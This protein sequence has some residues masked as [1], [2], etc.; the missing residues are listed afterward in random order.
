MRKKLD[1]SPEEI[2][3]LAVMELRD[4]FKSEAPEILL[5]IDPG[6]VLPGVTIK[7]PKRGDKKHLLD[8]SER[9]ARYYKIM[10]EHY[11][12]QYRACCIRDNCGF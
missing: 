8:L 3:G 7:V 11:R 2:L 9:N 5:S 10:V 12:R 4:R 6:F 1:E